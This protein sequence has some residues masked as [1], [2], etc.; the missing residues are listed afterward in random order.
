MDLSLDQNEQIILGNAVRILHPQAEED[1]IMDAVTQ[2]ITLVQKVAHEMGITIQGTDSYPFHDQADFGFYDD[3]NAGSTHD[4]QLQ[5]MQDDQSMQGYQGMQGTQGM[6]DNQGM[7]GYQG[8]QSYGMQDD[9]YPDDQMGMA[10]GS[11]A[12]DLLTHDNCHKVVSL[13]FDSVIPAICDKLPPLL[14]TSVQFTS[15]MLR[16]STTDFVDQLCCDIDQNQMDEYG[17]EDESQNTKQESSN[18]LQLFMSKN[19]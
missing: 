3:Q 10:G 11:M 16:H 1:Q 18:W 7:Q 8:M 4:Q 17:Y 12:S 2:A 13:M 9:Q 19:Q 15:S 14:Q 5:G 6:Q